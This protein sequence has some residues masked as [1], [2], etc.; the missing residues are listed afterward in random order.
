MTKRR[1]PPPAADPDDYGFDTAGKA[2]RVT[3]RELLMLLGVDTITCALY[4][5]C[6]KPFA[7]KFGCVHAA[8][9]YR[10]RQILTVMQS[11]RG[12]PRLPGPTLKQLRRALDWL[13]QAGLVTTHS[14]QNR[15]EKALKIWVILPKRSSLKV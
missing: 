12:G 2:F 5:R 7:D 15:R 4:M 10:F 3:P 6:L 9:Y 8:S 1:H 13:E 14:D 11:P